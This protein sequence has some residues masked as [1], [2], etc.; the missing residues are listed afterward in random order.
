MTTRNALLR[1]FLS[2]RIWQ[3]ERQQACLTVSQHQE[4]ARL[5]AS[6]SYQLNKPNGNHPHTNQITT[7]STPKVSFVPPDPGV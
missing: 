4:H 1:S 5:S 7:K 3:S 6:A 2:Q